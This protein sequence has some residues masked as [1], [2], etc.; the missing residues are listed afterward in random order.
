MSALKA[1]VQPAVVAVTRPG[2]TAIETVAAPKTHGAT[3][4][5]R[6]RKAGAPAERTRSPRPVAG[7]VTVSG[8]RHSGTSTASPTGRCGREGGGSGA[9]A[10]PAGRPAPP[11][12]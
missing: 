3:G 1:T 10:P 4:A 5:N 7:P 6:P 12:P 11:R 2:R 9:R 8:E